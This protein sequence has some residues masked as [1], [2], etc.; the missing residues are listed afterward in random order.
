MA[1][2]QEKIHKGTIYVVDGEPF[3][4]HE[5]TVNFT[6]T[7]FVLDFKSITPRSDPRTKEGVSFLLKHNVV[8]VEPWHAK[9]IAAVLGNIV[10]K[11]EEEFGEITKPK[12]LE[13]AEKKQKNLMATQK[14]EPTETPTYFG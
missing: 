14:K 4:S 1:R 2:E 13:K 5:L 9:R 3:F 7:Q 8:M 12:S 6:P 11:Y 10:K